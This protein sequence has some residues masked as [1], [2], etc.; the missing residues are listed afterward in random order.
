MSKHIRKVKIGV[1][2]LRFGRYLIERLRQGPGN[3]YLDVVAVCDR[4]EAL[5]AAAAAQFGVRAYTSFPELLADTELEAVGLFTGP[6]GRAELIEHAIRAGKDVLTTKPFELDPDKALAVLREAEALQRV[7]QL[8]S[9]G[10]LIAPDLAQIAVWRDQYQLGRPIGCRADAWHARAFVEQAD[11]SWYDDPSRCPVA[12]ISRIGIYLIN[13]LI[14][15]FGAPAT[16]Q[17]MH[18]RLITGRPTPDTA[19]LG[20]S[21]ANGALAT[22]FASFCIDDGEPGELSMVLNFER[23]TVYRN[24]G[25]GRTQSHDGIETTSL[26]L[27][28][29]APDG[30]AVR[31]EV[32][33]HGDSSDYQWAAFH[34]AVINRVSAW[35]TQTQAAGR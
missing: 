3:S 13:D 4:E 33:V 16:V 26:K 31:D 28:A 23:G 1:V 8:N 22:I 21:F 35:G 9:P 14:Q 25:P 2:G 12:P 27:A 24:L 11:G 30:K 5:A 15:L 34:H 32:I 20:V 18:S 19:Q 10:P 6:E 7:V 29:R 17:V